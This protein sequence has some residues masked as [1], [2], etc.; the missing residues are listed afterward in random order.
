MIIDDENPENGFIEKWNCS[1]VIAALE[2]E[3]YT[4]TVAEDEDLSF[5]ANNY[6]FYIFFSGR[7]ARL[8]TVRWYFLDMEAIDNYKL[9]SVIN[10]ANLAWG[11]K[12]FMTEP[13]EEDDILIQYIYDFIVP[14]S[15]NIDDIGTEIT[16]MVNDILLT[17]ESLSDKLTV[18]S[19][20]VYPQNEMPT[21]RGKIFLN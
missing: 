4:V 16:T 10:E 2:H 14:I 20:K 19:E 3:G 11:P 7:Y 8:T 12:I 21:R 1:R 9:F 15:D 6:I 13:D 5:E 18:M 17:E